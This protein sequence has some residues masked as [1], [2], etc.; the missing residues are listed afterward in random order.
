MTCLFDP[1]VLSQS[2]KHI[3][4]FY[5]AFPEAAERGVKQDDFC[6]LEE[7]ERKWYAQHGC[8]PTKVAVPKG[9]IVLWDSRLV[10]DNC[11]WVCVCL[12]VCLSV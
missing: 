8:Q 6:V 11:R 3:D 10:H 2:H 12:F 9:G 4:Q 7:A 5:S 1:R